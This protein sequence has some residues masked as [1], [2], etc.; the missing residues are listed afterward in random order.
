M[1]QSPVTRH[2]S[3]ALLTLV[4]ATAAST[5]NTASSAPPDPLVLPARGIC[6]HRGAMATHPENTIVALK[7][8][9]RLGVH[10]V[11][12]DVHWTKDRQLVLMHDRS[13]DRT[14]NG[15]G[16][17]SSFTLAEIRQ[18]D[19]GSWKGA[20]FAGERI[21]TLE[22]TLKIMPENVW[23]FVDI[24]YRPHLAAPVTREILR[25]KRRRQC[26]LLVFSHEAAEAARQVDPEVSICN[27]H[28]PGYDSENVADVIARGYHALR[29]TGIG[30]PE[31]VLRLKEAN[32]R[33][34]FCSGAK[35]QPSLKQLFDAGI[36]F[37]VVD[38]PA[39]M[40]T[41]AGKL[42]IKPLKPVYRK[43]DVAEPG[44]VSRTWLVQ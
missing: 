39:R 32:V 38:D 44:G 12:F 3:F 33:I 7:E 40:I 14:T 22:E 41:A 17:V 21:P 19:A 31:N 1:C 5:G 30:S 16:K 2:G 25:Q 42:G 20:Q 36:D 24:Q 35:H 34:L 26:M 37:P 29:F 4:L 43:G 6:A 10:V 27:T 18:L 15:T 13:V 23:L 28:V 9:L 8:A 11:E